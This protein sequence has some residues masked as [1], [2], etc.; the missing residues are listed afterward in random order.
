ME[1]LPILNVMPQV[2][3]ALREQG[4]AVLIAE[5][6]AG[7]TTAVPPALLE[8]AWMKGQSVL[9]LEPRR[10]AARSAA[11]YMAEQMGEQPGGTVGYRMRMD[12]KAGPNTRITVVTEGVL[13]RMLQHDPSLEGVGIVIFDEFHERS[14]HADLGLALTLEA[15]SVL[16]DDLRVLVMSATLDGEAVSGVLGGAPVIRCEGRTYPV[17]T[18]YMPSGGMGLEKAAAAGARKALAESEGD[19]LVFLPGEREIRRVQEELES[20]PLPAD[21]AI[22]PLYARLP[23]DRQREAVAP[24]RPGERKV[25]LSTSIAETSLTI[26]GVRSVVDT[27]VSRTQLFSPRTGMPRLVTVPVSKAAADQRRGRAGRTAPGRCY[28]LWSEE[29]HRRLPEAAEPEIRSADLASLALELAQWGVRDPGDLAWIDP[30]PAAAYGQAAGLL[31]TLGALDA[32]GAV[33]AHGRDMA[34]LGC[35]PRAAHM[36]LRAADTGAAPLAARLAA[37]LQDRDLQRGPGGLGSDFAMRAA[38]LLRYEAAGEAYGGDRAALRAVERE[39]RQLM[40]QLQAL[41]P[42]MAAAGPDPAQTGLLLSFAYPDRIGQSRGQGAYMLSGGRGA[43]LTPDSALAG[44]PYLVAVSVDDQGTQGRILLAAE[45][46]EEALLA[47]HKDGISE[48]KEAY[49]DAESGSAKLRRRLLL[50]ALVLKET[51]HGRPPAAE[52]ASL[53]LDAVAEKGLGLLPWDKETLQLR[54][55]LAFM[56]RLDAGWPDMTDEGLLER[57]GTW[58]GPFVDGLG[59]L[60][61]LKKV[62]L[63]RALESEL[64]WNMRQ[65]LEREAPTHIKVPSGSRVA[66]DYGNPAAPVLAVR[67]QEMFGQQD[68]PRI[69]G[70]KVPVVLHLLSP[71]RRPVQVTS[72]LAGFWQRTYFDVKKDLKGRYPKHYW[73]DNPLEAAATSR[74][75]P[76]GQ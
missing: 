28:R 18:V 56:H 24:S 22:R 41:R 11:A 50:G 44:S 67:L 34:A 32:G 26:H 43:A 25:V 19:V 35:H 29:E 61:E 57:I 47:H 66:V 31:R 1:Q 64:D 48:K 65:Q 38:S 6:G 74:V 58:L 15:K 17:E 23:Q 70:G 60:R 46:G 53:L 8:Q 72:D 3:Q 52:A 73:P 63:A 37:L 7:K 21:A 2:M 40:A 10:L 54:E 45:I 13:T 20:A 4:A 59:S 30:P 49:W 33:T 27:G 12:T 9:M 51:E 5:P 76:R 75:R 14:L 55:R 62:P 71:A 36:L 39:S 42:A 16:R 69:G 68:T